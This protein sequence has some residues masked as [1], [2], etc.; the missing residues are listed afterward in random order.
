MGGGGSP[1]KLDVLAPP[2]PGAGVSGWERSRP[3]LHLPALVGGAQDQ[4]QA[5]PGTG[6]HLG[7][8]S[9]TAFLFG[10]ISFPELCLT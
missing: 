8:P 1:R 2:G 9:L 3:A 7:D 4:D 5:G 6:Q 10:E